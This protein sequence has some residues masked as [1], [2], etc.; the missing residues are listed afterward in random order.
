MV[1]TATINEIRIGSISQAVRAQPDGCERG[2]HIPTVQMD[3]GT[4]VEVIIHV[5]DID[6]TQGA[7]LQDSMLGGSRLP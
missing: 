2:V 5:S 7:D 6:R 3:L 4:P 1:E